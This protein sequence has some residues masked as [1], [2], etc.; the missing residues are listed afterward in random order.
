MAEQ[1]FVFFLL[2]SVLFIIFPDKIKN[3]ILLERNIMSLQIGIVGL[4]NVGKSTL[5]QAITKKEVNRAQH[6]PY[7]YQGL[8]NKP[9]ADAD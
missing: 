5:F 3:K 2:P 8:S 9:A 1:V 7:I 6:R 4:P